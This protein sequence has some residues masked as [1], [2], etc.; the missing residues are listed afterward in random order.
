MP[1]PSAKL[2]AIYLESNHE[3]TDVI[4]QIKSSR[5]HVVAVVSADR[6]SI[7]QSMVNLKILMRT[8]KTFDREMV[9]VSTDLV[10]HSLA[11]QL[12]IRIFPKLQ[13]AQQVISGIPMT[14]QESVVVSSPVINGADYASTATTHQP[15]APAYTIPPDMR[16]A[17]KSAP[18]KIAF[19][20]ALQHWW[21]RLTQ[22]FA[23]PKSVQ[24]E[25][26]NRPVLILIAI[27]LLGM[28]IFGAYFAFEVMPNADIT[29]SQRTEP[30]VQQVE[31][32]AKPAASSADYV[33]RAIPSY[34]YESKASNSSTG[35]STGT[36]IIGS[37]ATGTVDITNRGYSQTVNLPAGTIL[38]SYDG[39]T[40]ATT[41]AVTIPAA[42][43]DAGQI[44]PA[45]RYKVSLVASDV[46]DKYN[47]DK[48]Q[49]SITG[50]DA[51]YLWAESN[52]AF[53][54]G[55][56]HNAV[57]VSQDDVDKVRTQ[58]LQDLMNK[59]NADTRAQLKSGQIFLDTALKNVVLNETINPVVGSE[60]SSFSITEQVVAQGVAITES[61]IRDLTERTMQSAVP[62]GFETLNGNKWDTQYQIKNLDID[63]RMIVLTAT[64]T[65]QIAPKLNVAQ[66][67]IKL[68]DQSLQTA[69]DV[70]RSYSQEIDQFDIKLQPFWVTKIPHATAKINLTQVSPAVFAD[71]MKKK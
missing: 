68:A 34:Y 25:T 48:N 58:L 54:G 18:Q 15:P 46:G 59:T 43:L 14:A 65:G 12:K 51:K 16:T 62:E 67:K 31:V 8:A 20:S 49:F 57:V 35:A 60:A 45:H 56:S 71:M 53:T 69:G 2:S 6:H 26:T 21:N 32:T 52:T 36:K 28:T 11:D 5:E 29:V 64:G 17:A 4:D 41:D 30:F 39:K 70:L 63:A 1:T 47:V 66:I 9:L 13:T 10:T 44:T 37:K 38:T 55:D 19:S 42:Q 33:N 3:I 23:K 24:L 40:F 7:L 22:Q 27:F 50:Y 61:D